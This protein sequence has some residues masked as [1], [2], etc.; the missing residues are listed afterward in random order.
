M[1][2]KTSFRF[3]RTSLY[4]MLKRLNSLVNLSDWLYIVVVIA[5]IQ[6]YLVFN[7]IFKMLAQIF[8][9]YM[10]HKTSVF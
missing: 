5:F 7:H 4:L 3:H 10:V 2:G 6:S 1:K 8:H 9:L